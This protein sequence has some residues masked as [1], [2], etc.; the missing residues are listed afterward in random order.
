MPDRYKKIVNYTYV[1]LFVVFLFVLIIIGCS[2]PYTISGTRWNLSAIYNPSSSHLHPAF[3]VYHS[4]DNSSLLYVKLFPNELLFNQANPE[5]EFMSK[6]SVQVQAYEIKDNKPELADSITYRYTIKQED[7]GRRFLSQIP[8]K[9]DI[10]KHYQLRIVTRDLL[11]RE[12][13]LRFLEVDKINQ[14]SEQNFNIL[15]NKGIPYFNNVMHEGMI[16]KIQH[17]NPSEDE[18]F[19]YY[20]KNKSVLPKPTFGSVETEKIYRVPDSLYIIEYSPDLMLSFSYE[21]VY[22]FKFDTTQ[23][24]GFIITNFGRNFP[25]IK[26]SDALIEPLAY[27]TTSADYNNLMKEENKKLAADNFWLN[28]AGSTGRAREM[29][30]IYYN[31]VYFSNYYFSNILPGWKTDRGMVYIVYGPPQNMEKTATSETWIFYMK[32]A[33]NAINFTFD[34]KPEPNN[35]ENFVLRRSESHEWHWREAVDAWRRGEIFLMD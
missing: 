29:I 31:R 12:L 14:Y 27:I 35:V 8:L 16:Y 32:G 10:G 23:E 26:D 22:Q 7:V 21:G 13:N 15:N 6:V 20:Y 4:T 9:L 2:S 25:K 19:I 30:R 11:R 5:K 3:R 28:L 17:R 24:G 1:T 33:N 34:Y 18:L